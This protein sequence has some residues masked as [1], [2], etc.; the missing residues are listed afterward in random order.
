MFAWLYR[1]QFPEITIQRSIDNCIM[2]PL[3]KYFPL[4]K[5]ST[6]SLREEKKLPRVR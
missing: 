3:T 1:R 5:K 4:L 6:K 2:L